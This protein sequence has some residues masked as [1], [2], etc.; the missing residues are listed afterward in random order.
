VAE[1]GRTLVLGL[2]HIGLPVVVRYTPVR[3]DGVEGT[4]LVAESA[5]V[6]AGSCPP[7]LCLSFFLS[8]SS[9]DGLSLQPAPVSPTWPS[10]A[11][12]LKAPSSTVRLSPICA[13][14]ARV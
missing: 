13:M 10:V 2:A 5:A 3:D 7:S 8:F 6:Q 1:G 14:S 4:P 12:W 11:R 9:A